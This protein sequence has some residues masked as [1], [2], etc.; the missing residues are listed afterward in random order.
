[1]Y[2]PIP[3][4][5]GNSFHMGAKYPIVVVTVAAI[6]LLSFSAAPEENIAHVTFTF[7]G[8]GADIMTVAYPQLS[9]Y[10]YTGNVYVATDQ[11]GRKGYLSSDQIKILNKNEWQIGSR[12]TSGEPFLS[13]TGQ[14]LKCELIES[15]LILKGLNVGADSVYG[16]DGNNDPWIVDIV[17]PH[18]TTYMVNTG[19]KPVYNSMPI[20]N[21]YKIKTVEVTANT[22]LD[23]V[24]EWVGTAR[25]E[26]KWLVLVFHS[27][28]K[29]N[30]PDTWQSSDFKKLV[31]YV[32]DPDN[33]YGPPK[34]Y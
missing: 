19:T 18:Y 26:H 20:T 25:V 28:D 27:F 30:D 10:G 21:E 11:I 13:M 22:T 4:G 15:Q 29:P 3:I 17:R 1:M 16:I 8:T 5:G 34:Q 6:L 2:C 31:Q 7:D 23:E 9:Q 12:G 24:K 33:L 14:E 32:H